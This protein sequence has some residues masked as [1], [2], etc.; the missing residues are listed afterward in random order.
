MAPELN[1]EIVMDG[2]VNYMPLKYKKTR[3]QINADADIAIVS[4]ASIF[5]K[6]TRDRFMIKL[7][8]KHPKYNFE[9]HVGYG[10]TEHYEALGN[11]GPLKFIH[12]AS[13]A[14]FRSMELT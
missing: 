13:F 10:T 14:P 9:N 1:E 6:V 2:S 5:A 7:A 12:R 4:A 3:C 11:F 8:K